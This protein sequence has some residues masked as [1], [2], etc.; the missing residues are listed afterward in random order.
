MGQK[1]DL[2]VSATPDQLRETGLQVEILAAGVELAIFQCKTTNCVVFSL[3]QSLLYLPSK[4]C[5]KG[6][7]HLVY[8]LSRTA[9]VMLSPLT[10]S[11]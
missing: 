1:P 3:Q 11:S 5:L 7:R 2:A 9:G 8:R 6:Q 10:Q 4:P